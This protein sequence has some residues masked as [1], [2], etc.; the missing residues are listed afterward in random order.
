M[1][2]WPFGA[3]AAGTCTAGPGTWTVG[4]GTTTVFVIGGSAVRTTVSR[5]IASQSPDTTSCDG[6]SASALSVPA[7]PRRGR[8]SRHGQQG[9]VAVLAVEQSSPAP[10]V[11]AS[12]P[13]PPISVSG[14]A[15][16]QRVVAVSPLTI[17]ARAVPGCALN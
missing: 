12:M 2:A 4:P 13:E 10:P 7:P 9:V 6:P 16:G 1:P 5:S 17:I 3:D 14:L 11:S 15:A 8:T